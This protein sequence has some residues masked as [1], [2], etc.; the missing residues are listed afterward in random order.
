MESKRL[1]MKSALMAAAA[2]L[3]SAVRP[4]RAV[5]IIRDGRMRASALDRLRGQLDSTP[6]AFGSGKRRHNPAGTKLGKQVGRLTARHPVGTH[7]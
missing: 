2:A 6:G 5:P 3:A 1:G 4:G 7:Y